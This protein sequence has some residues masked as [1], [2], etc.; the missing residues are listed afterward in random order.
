MKRKILIIGIDGGTWSVLGPAVEAGCMPHLKE[1]LAAGA[2]GVLESTLPAIT[3]AAWGS[4]Q[5]GT[6]PGANG[7][8]DFSYWDRKQA[9][10][11]YVSSNSLRR[12]IWEI[13]GDAGRRV[14]VV[15]VPMTY[16]PKP[17][18]GYMVTGILTPSLESGFTHPEG[19]K[20]QLLE[21]IP[22]YHVFNMQNVPR[23]Y[24]TGEQFEVF[25]RQMAGIVENRARAAEFIINKE[26]LDVFMVHFQ[27]T[28]V[29]QHLL[30]GYLDESHPDFDDERRKFIFDNFYKVLDR[31]IRKV[32]AD[33]EKSVGGDYLTLAVSDHGFQLHQKR[34][35]VGNWLQQ[36]GLLKVNLK[37]F[38][39]PLLK[40]FTRKFGLGRYFRPFL[41][42]QSL[43]KVEKRLNPD[44]VPIV[45]QGSRAL[46]LGRGNEGFIYLL[47]EEQ[48]QRDIL[49]NILIVKLCSIRDPETGCE[50][51]L[52][53]HRKQDVFKGPHMKNMP[54]LVIEPAAGYSCTGAYRFY[55]GIFDPIVFG[56][57]NHAGKHHKDGVVL[58]VGE[59]VRQQDSM[60]ARLIDMTPTRLYYLG[61]PVDSG[62]DGRVVEEMFEDGF[63]DR[64]GPVRHSD[65]SAGTTTK[66][67][68]PYSGEDEK[69]IE[70]RLKDLGYL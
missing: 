7:V 57:D 42:K 62:M 5:T 49:A 26:P 22:E 37:A 44:I 48:S 45:L 23:E 60:R 18:N 66:A 69:K 70:Q 20:G 9:A 13:A 52:A 1:L 6:N 16:P 65:V 51:L 53:V 8:F 67:D 10:R 11:R 43:S 21:A 36:E 12:T 68:G 39:T 29:C 34:F 64:L 54:D 61:L 32:R 46:A 41:S 33:F 31:C 40:R 25:V 27:A 50:V 56:V 28:D 58:A 2:G 17:V 59:G 19:L 15:N 63:R 3:P 24:P 4:F 35:N 47:E 14:G 55:K 38:R 30:W